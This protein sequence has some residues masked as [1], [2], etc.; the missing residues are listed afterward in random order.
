MGNVLSALGSQKGFS[1]S[2]IAGIAGKTGADMQME[3]AGQGG[4]I[5]L[6]QQ[7]QAQQNLAN[8]VLAKAG[9]QQQ[10]NIAQAGQE[11]QAAGRLT[12]LMGSGM[13]AA[14]TYYGLKG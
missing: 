14:G 8:M 2:N 13:Q 7:Q 3:T 12:Q 6:Q 11:S 10:Q 1:A 4:L 9:L 5:G